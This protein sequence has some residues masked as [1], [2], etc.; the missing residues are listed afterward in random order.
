MAVTTGLE[1]AIFE[2]ELLLLIEVLESVCLTGERE[3]DR[4][5]GGGF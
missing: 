2:N 1:L 5:G 3:G 4:A